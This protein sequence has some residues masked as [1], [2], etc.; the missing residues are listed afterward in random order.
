M[1]PFEIDRIVSADNKEVTVVAQSGNVWRL[2]LSKV[3]GVT[4]RRHPTVGGAL[5]GGAIALGVTGPLV[6]FLY[7]SSG[8]WPDAPVT[9]APASS[10]WP[11]I[12]T[13][14]VFT[15]IGAVI[16]AVI[17]HYS[18]TSD[19]FE[20]GETGVSLGTSSFSR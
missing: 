15:A 12:G 18:L 9:A 5:V 19:T 11:F 20:F 16:G 13:V 2:D 14:A 1:P 10:P 8:S 3:A 17:G 4:R 7:E 6:L